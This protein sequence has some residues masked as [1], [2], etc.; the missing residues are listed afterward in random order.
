MYYLYDVH[1]MNKYRVLVKSVYPNLDRR[2]AIRTLMK[3]GMYDIPLQAT[4]DP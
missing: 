3:S 4:S 2:S 1:N